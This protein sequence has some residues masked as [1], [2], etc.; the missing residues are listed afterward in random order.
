MKRYVIAIFLLCSFTIISAQK[1]NGV[2]LIGGFGGPSFSAT[3]IDDG[4][5]IM[6][7][8]GGAAVLSNNFFIGGYGLG[9]SSMV[10]NKSSLNGYQNYSVQRE[11]GGPWIGYI[12]RPWKSIYATFSLKTGFGDLQLNNK[13]ENILIYDKITVFTPQ[14]EMDF[15]LFSVVFLSLGA[16]YDH[17]LE[18]NL[19]SYNKNDF[20]KLKFNCSLKFGYF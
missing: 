17:F 12:Y 9:T 13:Q 1:N 10:S 6:M 16:S 3:K 11:Y 20:N 5:T 14:I 2:K 8:G 15:H 7:G 19:G 18:T 4:T